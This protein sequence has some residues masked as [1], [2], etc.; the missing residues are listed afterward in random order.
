[1][2][3]DVTVVAK[4]LLGTSAP[5]NDVTALVGVPGPPRSIRASSGRAKATVSWT[6]PKGSG[7]ARV[8]GYTATAAPGGFSCSTTSTL[9]TKANHSCEIA[10]LT[11]GTPYTVTVTATNAYGTGMP[12]RSSSV[13]PS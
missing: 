2:L 10:G 13:T 7:V 9:L 8:A 12:S 11:S 3:Y 5:S 4:G 1:V 6:A